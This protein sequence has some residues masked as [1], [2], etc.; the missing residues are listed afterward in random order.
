MSSDKAGHGKKKRWTRARHTFLLRTMSWTIALAARAKYHIRAE[1][2]KSGLKAPFLILYNHQT[3]FDQFF[4]MMSFKQT[5]YYLATEDIFSMGWPSSVIRWVVAPIPIKKQTTDLNAIRTML[6]VAREGGC[7]AIAPEGN[8]TYSGKTEYINPSI[9]SF[10][11]MLRLPIVLYRIE[12]GYGTQPRWSDKIRKG[13]MRSYVSRVLMPEEYAHMSNEALAREIEWGLNVN[14]ARADQSFKSKK[15]AEYLERMVYVCPYCGLSTFRSEGNAVEC[16]ACGRRVIYTP[17]K[18]LAGVGFEFPFR[19]ANDWYEYQKRYILKLDMSKYLTSPMFADSAD[20]SE[21]V[22]CIKKLPLRQNATL[23]LYADRV[24]ID[25]G[26]AGEW[27]IPFD[28]LSAA[29]VLGRN[30]LNLY[31]D[32]RIYQFRGDKRF[33]ALKYVNVFYRYKHDAKGEKSDYLGL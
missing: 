21:V 30:K 31:M 7:I 22:P 14:E 10:A 4:V 17:D 13:H 6:T 18:R 11:K 12:G 29:A 5:I 2:F 23:K 25:E 28:K 27:L 20:I 8:R 32:D 33:N 1:K 15:R 24:S 16:G 19:F 3:P 9:A 26:S